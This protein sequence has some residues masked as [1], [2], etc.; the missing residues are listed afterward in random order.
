MLISDFFIWFLGFEK[1]S[2][3]CLADF[4]KCI[5]SDEKVRNWICESACYVI[6]IYL[7]DVF[8]NLF[9]FVKG[10]GCEGWFYNL[11]VFEKL[12]VR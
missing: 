4:L 3:L 7:K 9:F 2:R 6:L 11:F 8:N 10:E 5:Y 1:I 12:P